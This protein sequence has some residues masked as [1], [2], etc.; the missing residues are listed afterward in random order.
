MLKTEEFHPHVVLDCVL[1]SEATELPPP[2][3][4]PGAAQSESHQIQAKA[5]L[6]QPSHINHNL[7]KKKKGSL[8]LFYSIKDTA[9]Q[10]RSISYLSFT[11]VFLTEHKLALATQRNHP[12]CFGVDWN[13]FL[14]IS[15]CKS[16]AGQTH[17]SMCIF[18]FCLYWVRLQGIGNFSWDDAH[19]K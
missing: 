5:A 18:P 6:Q 1:N 4:F 15:L 14:R 19:W 17:F 9:A 11:C 16:P 8:Q 3:P 12:R 2:T 13:S 7:E 10:T